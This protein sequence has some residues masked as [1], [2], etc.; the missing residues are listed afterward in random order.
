MLLWKLNNMIC[1][2]AFPFIREFL[3][4]I[5]T[6]IKQLNPHFKLTTIQK[7]WIAFCI[8]AVLVTESLCW[9]KFERYSLGKYSVAGL[10]WMLRHSKINWNLLLIGAIKVLLIKYNI[11]IG[12]LGL[13]DSDHQRSK[14]TTKIDKVHKIYDKKTGGYFMGQNL[15][16]LLLVTDKITIPVGFKFYIPDPKKIEWN[17]NDEKLRDEKVP[18]SERPKQ[19]KSDP[20]FPTKIEIAI[21]LLEQFKKYFPEITIQSISADAAYGSKDFFKQT[22]KIFPKTQIISQLKNNQ[23][24]FFKNK[25]ISVSE[26]FKS[27]P[28]SK[29]EIQIRGGKK[30]Q[31]T[32]SS[33]R[34]RVES[35][36]EFQFVVALKY[37]GED[38]FRYIV[39]SDLSWR[40]VDIVRAY[41]LRWLVEVF[42]SDWKRYEG[43]GQLA[44]QQGVEGSFRGVVLSLMVDL[45][46][47]FH[48]D[49]FAKIENKKSACTVGTLK[50]QIKNESLLSCFHEIL[51][52][53][54]PMENFSNLKDKFSEFFTSRESSKHMV[55]RN[56]NDLQP[57][58]SLEKRFG[59]GKLK[60][61]YM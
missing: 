17:K 25:I 49:Q 36:D 29:T 58:P 15:V 9:S 56:L 14:S 8:I 19:P 18:K 7:T 43:W 44:L 54:S 2:E 50:E 6:P 30:Q 31:V 37:D 55:N 27:L 21:Q 5:S 3:N 23:K 61:C 28:G 32:I 26:L 48:P 59:G 12:Q 47:L 16:F 33:A 38:E 11:K 35:H 51:M 60:L 10:S 45:C 22:N 1:H 40:A 20:N 57:S 34:V 52:S 53:D 4:C 41:S 13:D 24:V 42:I 46:L 39:A